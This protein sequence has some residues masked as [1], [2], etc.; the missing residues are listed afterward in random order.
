VS[1]ILTGGLRV[2][3]APLTFS[4][5]PQTFLEPPRQLPPFHGTSAHRPSPDFSPASERQRRDRLW[6][7]ASALGK[8]SVGEAAPAGA[9][10]RISTR[11]HRMVSV[12]PPGLWCL[13]DSTQ[14]L[15]A[16]LESAAPSGDSR[17]EESR[18]GSAPTESSGESMAKIPSIHDCFRTGGCATVS[19][20]C[21]QV[22]LFPRA[23]DTGRSSIRGRVTQA[24]SCDPV[25]AGRT[26]AYRRRLEACAGGGTGRAAAA[27][28]PRASLSCCGRGIDGDKHLF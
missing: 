15:R 23:G 19:G 8:R 13:S 11:C 6:P 18:L 3:T 16:G 1:T 14:R 25:R 9:T 4:S 26:G 5:S 17:G 10:E 7:R 24:A 27:A 22:F 21:N 12:A 28:R 20:D 2:K